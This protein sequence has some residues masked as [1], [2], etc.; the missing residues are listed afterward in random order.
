MF[1]IKVPSLNPNIP[2]FFIFTRE[3]SKAMTVIKSHDFSARSDISLN[4]LP[5]LIQYVEFSV[6]TAMP[7]GKSVGDVIKGI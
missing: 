6:L 2:A 4:L 3:D 5:S 1:F 7:E